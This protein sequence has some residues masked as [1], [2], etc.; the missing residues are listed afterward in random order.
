VEVLP[1]APYRLWL[2][3]DDGSEGEVD[4][5]HLSDGAAFAAWQDESFFRRAELG[6]HGEVAWG[7]AIE[8]C[9]D[10]LYLRLTGRDAAELM[11]GLL[12]ADVRA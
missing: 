5:S 7:E 11:P 4:L 3:Y 8:L 10:A 1:R 12:R 6:P 9:P 2:R